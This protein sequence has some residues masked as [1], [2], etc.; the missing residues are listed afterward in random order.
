MLQTIAQ[1]YGAGFIGSI[2]GGVAAS[3]VDHIRIGS[4]L[5]EDIGAAVI[6][7]TAWPI[8]IPWFVYDTFT[9]TD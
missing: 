9:L 3:A 5:L 4:N 8:A 6:F 2:I 7:S 1:L